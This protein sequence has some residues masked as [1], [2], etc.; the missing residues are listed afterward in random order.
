[1]K[2]I[3]KAAICTVFAFFVSIVGHSTV[4]A[5]EDEINKLS[6]RMAKEIISA[7]KNKLAVVDFTDLQGDV[8]E[9]GRFLAEEFSVAL[10]SS[11]NDFNIID[12]VHLK[13]IIKEH[14]LSAT[15]LIDPATA[16]KLGKIAGVE[17]LVTGTITPFGDTVR[18]TVKIL[19]TQTAKVISGLRGNIAKTNA[20][21]ELLSNDIMKITTGGGNTPAIKKRKVNTTQR[22]EDRNFTFDMQTCKR[23]G[24]SVK[25]SLT[26][27]NNGQDKRLEILSYVHDTG[28]RAY[29]DY[30]N[31]Y[32]A[33]P[34]QL[35]N[36]SSDRSISNILVNDVP[37][38]AILTFKGVAS[39]AMMIALLK[40]HANV[41]R[42]SFFI[43]LRNIPLNK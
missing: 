27:T 24:S 37:T 19:D 42:K 1:M 39:E 16:R 41:D 38:K 23:S 11:G 43:S 14:K 29:D 13:S 22:V 12:R 10:S 17:A 30:G 28:T 21:E 35:A 40:I 2:L 34:I 33:E 9:L 36:K 20:I 26:I 15:G 18:L 3:S 5:Y 32:K 6:E 31:E 4:L 8:T 7:N 25:C